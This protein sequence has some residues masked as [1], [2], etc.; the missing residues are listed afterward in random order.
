MLIAFADLRPH[1]LGNHDGSDGLTLRDLPELE[2]EQGKVVFGK[3]PTMIIV[4]SNL[5]KTQQKYFTFLSEE[6]CTYLSE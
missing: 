3:M 1:T 5:S 4:R 6:G 2:I